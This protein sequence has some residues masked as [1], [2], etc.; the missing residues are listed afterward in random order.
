MNR[1]EPASRPLGRCWGAFVPENIVTIR[2]SSRGI[3]TVTTILI[4]LNSYLENFLSYNFME[5]PEPGSYSRL[6][7]LFFS[8]TRVKATAFRQ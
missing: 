5:I 8:L 4:P 2:N 7:D 6:R 3:R 1:S